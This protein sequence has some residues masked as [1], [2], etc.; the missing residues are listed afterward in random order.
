MPITTD[1]AI[2][3]AYSPFKTPIIG[4]EL[5]AAFIS[6][7]LL[8]IVIV[9]TCTY[10]LA[11]RSD[12]FF[13]QGVVAGMCLL[14][15]L[16]GIF[17]GTWGYA[18]LVT[19]FG[20]YIDMMRM[21]WQLQAMMFVLSSVPFIR[22]MMW[23]IWRV[24][25]ITLISDL[26]AIL[27][28]K[29]AKYRV[30]GLTHQKEFHKLVKAS[31][32]SVDSASVELNLVALVAQVILTVFVVNSS[33]GTWF[34]VPSKIVANIYP[35]SVIGSLTARAPQGTSGSEDFV[36]SLDFQSPRPR[37][38]VPFGQ[39][40]AETPGLHS[41]ATNTQGYFAGDEQFRDPVRVNLDLTES[42]SEIS[43]GERSIAVPDD[44]AHS[45]L[46]QLDPQDPSTPSIILTCGLV[47]RTFK[48]A[49]QS[50]SVWR[51]LVQ[52]R[53]KT[54]E[55]EYV[56]L[57]NASDQALMGLAIDP[58]D[59]PIHPRAVFRARTLVD[60][61]ALQAAAR[62]GDSV[63]K[64]DRIESYDTIAML[65]TQVYDA[66]IRFK[67]ISPEERHDYLAIRRVARA[68][69][70]T[71][72]R[73]ISM[74]RWRKVFDS[75]RSST[76]TFDAV[77][78]SLAG[79]GTPFMTY[80]EI[81]SG[82]Q[83]LADYIYEDTN[84]DEAPMCKSCLEVHLP[85][86]VAQSASDS[87]AR[88]GYKIVPA[89]K[90]TSEDYFKT[91]ACHLS[92]LLDVE[93]F[94][95][96]EA[97]SPPD[98]FLPEIS[99]SVLLAAAIERL[100]QPLAMKTRLHL[101]VPGLAVAIA[102]KHESPGKERWFICDFTHGGI[103]EEIHFEADLVGQ[104]EAVRRSMLDPSLPSE[105]FAAMF[106]EL[107]KSVDVDENGNRHI[108]VSTE[109]S[110]MLA[111]LA[112]ASDTDQG[113]DSARAQNFPVPPPD[114]TIESFLTSVCTE[115]PMDAFLV[116]KHF[117]ALLSAQTLLPHF[118]E[119][120]EALLPTRKIGEILIQPDSTPVI[121]RDV[122]GLLDFEVGEAC[123]FRCHDGDNKVG[124]VV[125]WRLTKAEGDDLANDTLEEQRSRL[126]YHVITAHAG[127]STSPDV[128]RRLK[129]SEQRN[130][131]VACEVL[132]GH[133]LLG[134]W[135]SSRSTLRYPTYVKT[136]AWA[137]FYP[138]E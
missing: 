94:Q 95:Q 8:G 75:E 123:M 83:R 27:L 37:A 92:T 120:F 96:L 78:K 36:K 13:I 1:P 60:R 107:S 71:L 28:I 114:L 17:D 21:P 136:K 118:D 12:H 89:E 10:F 98:I 128:L 80:D 47:S 40:G 30:E 113:L 91:E 135:F 44:V 79:F 38:G 52:E 110:L 45:I 111:F 99:A 19:G 103:R 48:A 97:S 121:R 5:I 65:G 43:L 93:S 69:E 124:V 115:Y 77:Y 85:G 132:E 39:S 130:W 68:L 102:E 51:P 4:G 66:I 87:L 35:L 117:H 104:P 16:D 25:K 29:P 90:V 15:V 50:A 42:V 26:N 24:H 81:E 122:K 56:K 20:D 54:G 49:A 6:F 22:T 53:W 138:V 137:A 14:N 116:R 55:P 2:I 64:T 133:G 57:A 11:F 33:M 134:E 63:E 73:G 82:I 126:V 100:P 70:P 109:V 106:K 72:T 101:G 31:H 3:A 127:I 88:L 74:E 41:F 61:I 119:T 108:S 129:R 67:T 18:Q 34:L 46:L 9:N 76:V 125:G 112:F 86:L 32:S 59:P 23:A 7:F 62:R 58:L 84:V 105:V 131:G